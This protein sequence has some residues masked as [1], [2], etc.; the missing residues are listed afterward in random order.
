MSALILN[1][2][3]LKKVVP[4]LMKQFGYKNIMA[5]PK[6]I[7][8]VI[9]CGVPEGTQ[10]AKA[11]DI[12]LEELNLIAGQAPVKKLAKK[13]IAGFKLKKND[14]IGGMV[15]MRG[16]RMDQFLNKLINICLPRV[17][18]FRGLNPKSFDGRGN[19][20][21]G[22]KEQLVFPEIDYDRVEKTRG[23]NITLVT[24]AN[25][26]EEARALLEGLGIPFTKQGAQ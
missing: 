12:A 16:K 19:Y 15:T 3:Y 2:K 5:V 6:M 10:N 17:R 20:S 18:D 21:F 9:S 7:K 25:S 14:P 23:M 1:E 24:S 8:V 22:I 13:A 11:C 26:N 4:A